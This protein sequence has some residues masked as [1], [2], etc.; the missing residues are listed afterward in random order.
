LL[1][2]VGNFTLTLDGASSSINTSQLTNI[3][4]LDV[5]ANNGAVLNLSGV[6]SYGG[7]SFGTTIRADNAGSQINL[8]NLTT[9]NGALNNNV[10]DVVVTGGGLVDLHQL[11]QVT[12]GAVRFRAYDAN[13]V[14][15]LSALT[16]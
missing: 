7:N 12:T 5:Y 6:T 13:S 8:G 3:N 1:T 11:P 14:I 2:S 10:V 9:L 16:Q 4:S 15:D